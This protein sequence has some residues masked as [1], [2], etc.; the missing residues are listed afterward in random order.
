M[1]DLMIKDFSL[2]G[3]SHLS[4]DEWVWELRD[5]L[6]RE[7]LECLIEKQED[8]INALLFETDITFDA[9]PE[10]I[11]D[12]VAARARAALVLKDILKELP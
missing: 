10:K 2:E 12:H 1:S 5:L 11:R 4:E 8:M 7:G 6:V 9:I 3:L